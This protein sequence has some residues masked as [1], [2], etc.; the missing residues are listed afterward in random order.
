[1]SHVLRTGGDL[2]LWGVTNRT[3]S[4][5]VDKLSSQQVMQ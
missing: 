4:P 2:G 5:N 1:M 3:D